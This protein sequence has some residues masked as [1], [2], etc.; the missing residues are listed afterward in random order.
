VGVEAP[1]AGLEPTPAELPPPD[2]EAAEAA[3]AVDEPLPDLGL[4]SFPI[5][6]FNS[7][8][9]LNCNCSSHLI[10]STIVAHRTL[11]Y[12]QWPTKR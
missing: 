10:T 4:E 11:F 2:A 9:Q 8:L 6:C 7:K 1:A 3:E 5:L 12:P